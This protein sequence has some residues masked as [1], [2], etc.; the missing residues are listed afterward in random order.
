MS[1]IHYA[2]GGPRFRPLL[3]KRGEQARRVNLE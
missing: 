2:T 3:A 1:L